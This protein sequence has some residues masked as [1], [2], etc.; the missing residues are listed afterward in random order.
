MFSAGNLETN[1]GA[2]FAQKTST[3]NYDYR[4]AFINAKPE[5]VG[6]SFVNW[7]GWSIDKGTISLR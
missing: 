3:S 5:K 4:S 1:K 7:I 2:A 6:G